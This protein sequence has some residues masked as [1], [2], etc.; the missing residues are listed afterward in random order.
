MTLHHKAESF[1]AISTLRSHTLILGSMPGI[2]SLEAQ[3]YYAHPQN[4]F[5]EILGNIYDAPVDTYQHRIAL[6][7]KNNLAM[8]DVLKFCRRRGSL[9]NRIDS[10]S[11][12]VNDF[13]FFL[14]TRPLI[15]RVFFNGT[16]AE[17]E[18]KKRVIPELS[19]PILARLALKRLP[20]TSPAHATLRPVDKLKAWRVVKKP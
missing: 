15:R 6:I 12:E 7:R 19:A 4:S 3:Q 9:D 8:W 2:R 5:W 13:D 14:R 16:K 1:P 20:S 17:Q 10:A 11:I 18:F